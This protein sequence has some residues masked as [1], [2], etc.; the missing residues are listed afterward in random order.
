[1]SFLTLITNRSLSSLY[2]KSCGMPTNEVNEQN[3][4]FMVFTAI[5]CSS[6]TIG[7]CYL[8]ALLFRLEEWVLFWPPVNEYEKWDCICAHKDETPIC[9]LN[10]LFVLLSLVLDTLNN[11][12]GMRRPAGYVP[13]RPQLLKPCRCWAFSVRGR[14]NDPFKARNNLPLSWRTTGSLSSCR[15]WIEDRRRRVYTVTSTCPL[16]QDNPS[17]WSIMKR[18]TVPAQHL[19]LSVTNWLHHKAAP[20]G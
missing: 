8:P 12:S 6:V 7:C 19:L 13:L 16:P 14:R 18:A 4:L 20:H 15:E 11:T 1:M 2:V 9:F 10:T 17:S 3:W 5:A